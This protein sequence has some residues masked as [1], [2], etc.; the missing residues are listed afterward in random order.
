MK[1]CVT[2]KNCKEFKIAKI[3]Y[4]L[5]KRLLLSSI[6]HECGSQDEKILKKKDSI[7]IIPTEARKHTL[8]SDTFAIFVDFGHFRKSLLLKHAN[9]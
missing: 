4:I 5:D 6:C 8:R 9:L 3:S 1:N 2:C 7:T